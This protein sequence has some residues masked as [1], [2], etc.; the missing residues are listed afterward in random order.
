M[1]MRMQL[2]VIVHDTYV[3]K[4]TM[5]KTI[6]ASACYIISWGQIALGF[7]LPLRPILFIATH[8]YIIGFLSA[9][10]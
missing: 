3:H 6:D 1:S 8:N 2:Y 4:A 5:E 9:W 10:I 7:F